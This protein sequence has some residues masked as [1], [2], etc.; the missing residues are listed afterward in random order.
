[1]ADLPDT[2]ESLRWLHEILGEEHR[3]T[4]RFEDLVARV[5]VS[6][7]RPPGAEMAVP[8]VDWRPG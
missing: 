1:M 6:G 2:S 3:A 7:F 8:P 5:A 4:R